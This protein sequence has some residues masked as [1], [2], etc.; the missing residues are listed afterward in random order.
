[1][2]A[3]TKPDTLLDI[4]YNINS[5]TASRHAPQIPRWLD[6][7]YN[8]NSFTASGDLPS[9]SFRWI[10]T[11]ILIALQLRVIYLLSLSVGYSLQY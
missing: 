4:H 1:M 11:T 8:I 6:I 3:E 2:P 10:F 9:V 5:F 7:H